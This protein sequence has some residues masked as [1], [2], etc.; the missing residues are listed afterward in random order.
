MAEVG[1]MKTYQGSEDE[2]LVEVCAIVNS[3][4]IGCPVEFHFDVHLSTIDET[5]GNFVVPFNGC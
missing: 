1:L 4:S 3:P 2:G 5:A